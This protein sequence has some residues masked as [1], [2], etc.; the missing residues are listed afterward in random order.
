M[1]IEEIRN[2]LEKDSTKLDRIDS[3]PNL[4]IIDY[5]DDDDR[6]EDED[7]EE[8]EVNSGNNDEN[9]ESVS[10]RTITSTIAF[11][12]ESEHNWNDD[13][14]RDEMKIENTTAPTSS[15]SSSSPLSSSSLKIDKENDE[16]RL[17]SD[18]DQNRTELLEKLDET[19]SEKNEDCGESRTRKLNKN[20]IERQP[21][22]DAIKM[23]V[24]QIPKEWSEANCWKLFEE[25]GEIYS[26][27]ILRDKETGQSRGCCFVTFYKRRSALNAQ[28]ALHN[29]RTLEN[30]HNPI[31]MKPADCK[32]K[33]ERKIFIGMLS[34]KMDEND[35]REMFS[36]FGPIEECL[37]LRDGK[38]NSRGCAFI[39]FSSKQC[40]LNS[41]K[42]IHNSRTMTGCSSPIVVK[43]ASNNHISHSH[44]QQSN[45][46]Q[47][48]SSNMKD[49][50]RSTFSSSPTNK[51]KSINSHSSKF[52]PTTCSSS[53]VPIVPTTI[54]NRFALENN[55]TFFLHPVQSCIAH[56]NSQFVSLATAAAAAVAA[57]TASN[58]VNNIDSVTGSSSN[59]SSGL[60]TPNYSKKNSNHSFRDAKNL[61]TSSSSSLSNHGKKSDEK[62][63][64]KRSKSS[65][66]FSMISQAKNKNIFK[67]STNSTATAAAAAAAA[68][69]LATTNPYLALAAV[70]VA[71]QHQNR[72]PKDQDGKRRTKLKNQNPNQ[73]L[74]HHSYPPSHHHHQHHHHHPHSNHSSHDST[75]LSSYMN[76]QKSLLN[77][78]IGNINIPTIFSN[79]SVIYP[80]DTPTIP[81]YDPSQ[82][83]Q[84]INAA[85]YLDYSPHLNSSYGTYRAPH[86]LANILNC[87]LKNQ[88]QFLIH[89]HG[90]QHHYNS[91]L[92]HQ[93][94]PLGS[95]ANNC[96]IPTPLFNLT[97]S[98]NQF[99]PLGLSPLIVDGEKTMNENNNG[100]LRIKTIPKS[101]PSSST[102][103]L[104]SISS[105]SSSSICGGIANVQNGNDPNAG[106][107]PNSNQS[108]LSQKQ[109]EGPDG[110]NLFIYHLPPEFGDH[111]LITMFSSFGTILS[112]KVFVDRHTNLSKCFG[113]VSFDNPSSAQLAIQTMNGFQIGLK[114]LKVQLKRKLE[115]P[116]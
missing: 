85:T 12:T 26:L 32:N 69:T 50:H 116:Y 43:L 114:R 14:D 51:S 21:D 6:D 62:M 99:D 58:T 29:I 83:N 84:T 113:F 68:A 8:R 53:S 88:D 15:S 37:V 115:K 65:N 107:D 90:H 10:S 27:K 101:F 25:F 4:M 74:A 17:T 78:S 86:S 57:A 96:G 81:V 111:D 94:Y 73:I 93:F 35:L 64:P 18:I 34:K 5:D 54:S 42:A 76:S 45:H 33:Q 41:I 103:S 67:D 106:F 3:E 55:P 110:S 13:F 59:S 112:A 72:S 44:H 100:I 97:S 38:Q 31:Q 48:Q 52:N 22:S 109:L 47:R 70:A 79:G 91:H 30:M 102:S 104:S 77:Q 87:N 82:I 36:K 11:D 20:Q 7:E 89:D 61:S 95:I 1:A 23:F 16:N 105:S 108:M 2:D 9:R 28:D 46:H 56:P 71:A 75:S 66:Q 24:G 60:S 92:L 19:M 49:Q 40:A 80:N 39:T 63:S 98:L